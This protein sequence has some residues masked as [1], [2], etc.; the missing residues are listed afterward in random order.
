[1]PLQRY[2][3]RARTSPDQG[4]DR[5]GFGRTPRPGASSR[6]GADH[7]LKGMKRSTRVGVMLYL[8]S[9]QNLSVEQKAFL[10]HA[11]GKLNSEE[12]VRALRIYSDLRSDPRFRAR[13]RVQ[14]ATVP[15]E[16]PPPKPKDPRRIGIGYRD[17]GSLRPPHRPSLPG[18]ITLSSDQQHHL[19]NTFGFVPQPILEGQRLTADDFGLRFSRSLQP[20]QR[21]ALLRGSYQEGGYPLPPRAPTPSAEPGE[22]SQVSSDALIWDKKS[23][24]FMTIGSI[25]TRLIEQRRTDEWWDAEDPP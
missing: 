17:K 19:Q 21:S 7:G 16:V 11:Q 4:D 1:M 9:T 8:S 14:H 5:E 13:L 3:R 12:L 10:A 15:A 20:D 6:N 23:G 25:L 24:R 2:W 18:E 22:A